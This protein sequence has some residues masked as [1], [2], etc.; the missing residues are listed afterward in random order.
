MFVVYL[1]ETLSLNEV[2]IGLVAAIGGLGILAGTFLPDLVTRR[3]G[4]GRGILAA[5]GLSI[6]AYVLVA[7]A[8]GPLWLTIGIVAVGYVFEELAATV[9][10][11]NQFTLRNAVTPN[12]LRGRVA[13]AARVVL[14]STVPIGFLAGGLV[15]DAVGL[16]SAMLLGAIG[17][18]LFAV[19][20][21][22]SPIIALRALP[23][24]PDARL[25]TAA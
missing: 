22:R 24:D 8:D 19:L 11:I 9:A 13:S 15:A 14:R 5:L 7:L 16:R 23:P 25:H 18:L 17:P 20:I 10:D 1:L 2:T 12:R 21:V 6:P 3:L 4:L